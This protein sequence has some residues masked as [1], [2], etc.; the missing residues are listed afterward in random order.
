MLNIFCNSYTYIF[1]VFQTYVESVSAVIYV[2][3]LPLNCVKDVVLEP[4]TQIWTR[5][6]LALGS[7]HH[8]RAVTPCRAR[9]DSHPRRTRSPIVPRPQLLR[10][11]R[12]SRTPRR[13]PR[14]LLLT[15]RAEEIAQ[16][17]KSRVTCKICV[18]RKENNLRG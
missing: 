10:T 3:A 5:L 8:A 14:C 1:L 17:K 9:L 12:C 16:P 7:A 2:L 13:S 6:P 15:A 4:V 11:A 18:A